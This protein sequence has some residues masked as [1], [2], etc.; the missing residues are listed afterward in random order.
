MNA[1]RDGAPFSSLWLPVS[2][3]G[4]PFLTLDPFGAPQLFAKPS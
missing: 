1:V 2:P 3:L 4:A